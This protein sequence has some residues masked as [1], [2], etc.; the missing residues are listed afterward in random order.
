MAPKANT[1]REGI[2]WVGREL[3]NAKER[4]IIGDPRF[5]EKLLEG[6]FKRDYAQVVEQLKNFYGWTR[7]DLG[8][9]LKQRDFLTELQAPFEG[10]IILHPEQSATSGEALLPSFKFAGAFGGLGN[11]PLSEVRALSASEKK[12]GMN[13]QNIITRV[14]KDENGNLIV[15]SQNL[16]KSKFWNDDQPHETLPPKAHRIVDSLGVPLTGN[17]EEDIQGLRDAWYTLKAYK[18]TPPVDKLTAQ[19]R[20]DWVS[21]VV[22]TE[23]A[24]KAL[25]LQG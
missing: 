14:A 18:E 24:E 22:K 3:P 12:T 19:E 9:L 15:P 8:R 21:G 16:E 1:Q 5:Y 7:E 13:L 6:S 17:P 11:P 10:T 25:N 4:P 20:Y 2:Q 23:K